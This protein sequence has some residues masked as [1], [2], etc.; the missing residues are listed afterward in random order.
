MD[1][2]ARMQNATTIWVCTDCMLAHNGHDV[3]QDASPWAAWSRDVDVTQGMLA[4]EHGAIGEYDVPDCPN[5][6][7]DGRWVGGQECECERIEFSTYPCDGCNSRLAGSRYAFTV[8]E[9]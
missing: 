7:D 1:T 4:A 8:W 2:D 3:E 9:R 6:D 5:L